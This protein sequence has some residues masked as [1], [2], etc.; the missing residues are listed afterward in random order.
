LGDERD[1]PKTRLRR[2]LDARREAIAADEVARASRAACDR[3][4]G[5][6]AF[7][8]TSVVVLYAA[9]RAE[10]DPRDLERI[11]SGGAAKTFYYP[12]VEGERLAFRRAT[13]GELS[14]GRYGIL[15]PPAGAPALS[16]DVT[17][18]VAV[19]PGLAFDRAGGRLGTGKGYYDRTLSTFP[20]LTRIGLAMDDLVVDRLPTDPW[21][22]PMHLIVTEHDSL[23]VDAVDG[24]GAGD[25][26]WR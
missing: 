3:L 25:L 11:A 5:L 10:L 14:P 17:G 8:E 4:G 12:R 24:R 22:V 18:A 7:R 19:V 21:D 15:E 20:G 1:S 16:P 6:N 23:V 26:P 2:A 9:R 13:F